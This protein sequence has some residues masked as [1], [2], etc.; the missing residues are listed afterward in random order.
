MKRCVT[1]GVIKASISHD[2]GAIRNA[3]SRT[4]ATRKESVRSRLLADIRELRED[5]RQAE[6]RLRE[7]ED[8]CAQCR[9]VREVTEEI[10]NDIKTRAGMQVIEGPNGEVYPV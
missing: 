3:A 4:S 9:E 6:A 1:G 7:H 10:R 5:V 2:E 8:G